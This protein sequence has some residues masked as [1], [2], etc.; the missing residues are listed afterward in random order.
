MC[1]S[2][3]VLGGEVI[4]TTSPMI[5]IS[6]GSQGEVC[7]ELSTEDGNSQLLAND[8]TISFVVQNAEAGV[9]QFIIL[10]LLVCYVVFV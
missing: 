5:S 2:F 6:E 1:R 3:T 8:L 7:V 9:A 4:L 10:V